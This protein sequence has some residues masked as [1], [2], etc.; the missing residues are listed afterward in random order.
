MSQSIFF[1]VSALA[2]GFVAPACAESVAPRPTATEVAYICAGI[3]EAQSRTTLTDLR[4]DVESVQVARATSK[5]KPFVDHTVGVDI[6]VR[7]QPGMTAQWLARLVECH[8]ASE[9]GGD[10]CTSSEC[11]LGLNRV[12]T[13]VSAT[14]TGF[15]ISL[16]SG[17]TTVAREIARRSQLIFETNPL[18]RG[19]A[20]RAMAE[21]LAPPNQ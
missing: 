5:T 16:R 11:P 1:L 15:S 10:F 8:V 21:L 12:A 13:S 18:R 9:A 3:A 7:A 20:D 17:D 19:A 4:D 2:T 6:N 14:A